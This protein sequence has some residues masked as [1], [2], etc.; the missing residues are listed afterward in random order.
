M[1]RLARLSAAQRQQIINDFVDDVFA[2]LPAEGPGAGIAQAMRQIPAALP[3]EPSDAQV[4]AWIELAELV[5]DASFR[6]RV[7]DMAVAGAQDGAGAAAGTS[8]PPVD[9]AAVQEHAGGALA[10]GVEPGSAAGLQVLGRIL[11]TLPPPS[12]RERLADRLELF[13]DRRVER[14]WQLLGVLNGWP[15]S[16]PSVPAFE[17]LISALRSASAATGR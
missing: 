6:A 13:T 1:H 8:G 14:Y 17:W 16:P 3:Q 11:G 12:D 10:A 2:D 7:R 9:P 15:P 5:G 4:D